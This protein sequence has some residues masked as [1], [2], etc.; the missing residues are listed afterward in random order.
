MAVVVPPDIEKV[1]TNAPPDFRKS[2][3]AMLVGRANVLI[4]IAKSS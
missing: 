3:R 1:T 2:R 4:V